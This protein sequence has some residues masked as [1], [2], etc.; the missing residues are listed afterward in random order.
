MVAPVVKS[1]D[2][3]LTAEEARTAPD[4]VMGMHLLLI[5]LFL[6]NCLL[7]FMCSILGSFLVNG[8]FALVLFD[9]GATHILYLL[10][11]ERSLLVLRGSQIVY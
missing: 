9:S 11:S 3:Q 5:S 8:I 6:L 4:V 7:M 2:F 10:R 1:R